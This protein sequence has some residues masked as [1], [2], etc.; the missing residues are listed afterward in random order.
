[1]HAKS[2]KKGSSAPASTEEIKPELLNADSNPTLRYP[3]AVNGEGS[4]SCGWFDVTRAGVR[5]SVVVSG[6]AGRSA[7]A[8]N[9]FASGGPDHLVA[10]QEAVADE[11]F[12]ASLSEIREAQFA[13]GALMFYASQRRKFLIYFPQSQW[14]LAQNPRAFFEIAQQNV[15]GTTAIQ[16]AM[17]SF[18]SALA[19]VKP[20][21]S[22]APEVTL[23]AEPSS[24][25]KGHPVTL[26]WTSSNATSLDLEPGGGRV[27]AAGGTSLVPNDS[28]NYT[29]T[30]T[31]PGGTKVA[32]VFVTVAQPTV[33]SPPTLV[34]VEPSAAGP[35]QTVEVA[36][37][38]LVIRGVVMDASG[39]P[40]VTINGMSVSMRP[41]SA[42]AAQFA[43]DPVAL[44]PGENRFEVIATNN[45]RGQAKM[46]FTVR[47][48][49]SAPQPQP[50]SPSNPKALGKAD[51][52]SLLQGEVSSA[53]VAELVKERGIKFVPTPDDLRDIRSA[54]G[55]DDLIDALNQAPHPARN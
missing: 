3:V 49:S 18:E 1:L 53:H 27:A 16:Q 4:V 41:T 10:P 19:A 21:V 11:G 50:A 48:T 25:E 43:S 33:A 28:T 35:G 47:Y 39:I 45:A 46:A 55:G 34:L 9:K 17:T 20:P 44:Q 22:L 2:V 26:V 40:V 13:K 32:S 12:G 37:S 8:R 5:Y 54:G 52:L 36:T 23:H 24:V 6:R 15:A 30:A 51:I 7:P 29:L 14:G 42:Q 31:G 38:S